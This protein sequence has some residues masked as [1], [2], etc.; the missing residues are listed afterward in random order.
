MKR[1]ILASLVGLAVPVVVQAVA[2]TLES[3]VKPGVYYCIT[4]H[5]VGIQPGR[6]LL[7][8]DY[9]TMPGTGT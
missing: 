2:F 9:R 8:D 3:G 4:D 6:G 5:M 1:I 7:Q